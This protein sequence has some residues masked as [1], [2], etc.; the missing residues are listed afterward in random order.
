ML[1]TLKIIPSPELNEVS[2]SVEEDEFGDELK[3]YMESMAQTMYAHQGVGLA[4]VQVGD[5]RRIL[6]ADLGYVRTRVYGGEFSYMVNPEVIEHA[7]ETNKMTEGCLS[8]PG[9]EEYVERP[10]WV[11]IRYQTPHG[12]ELTERFEGYEARILLHEMD[13]FEGITLHSRMSAFKKRRYRKA[14]TKKLKKL[15]KSLSERAG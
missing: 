12:E 4:G 9:L 14:L 1:L 13:H 5:M 10:D 8:F 11:V 3:S 2:R 7:V 6:V 15:G